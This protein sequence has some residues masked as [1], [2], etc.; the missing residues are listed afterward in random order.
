[1]QN[2]P[3]VRHVAGMGVDG[4]SGA[5]FFREMPSAVM[6]RGKFDVHTGSLSIGGVVLDAQ[7]RKRNLSAHHLKPL[8]FGHSALALGG[9]AVR[10][11]FREFVIDPLFN[12]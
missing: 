8:P 6:A 5:D 2:A 12:S 10:T 3:E 1:M 4:K 11:E 9:G 7:V